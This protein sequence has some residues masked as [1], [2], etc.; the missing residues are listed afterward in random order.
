MVLPGRDVPWKAF[1]KALGSEYSGDRVSDTAGS[2]TFFAVLAIF[3]FLL[4]LVALASVVISPADA[5]SLVQQ[6]GRV[7]PPA[8]TDILSDRIRALGEDRSLGLLTFSALAAIWAA[9]GGIDALTRALNV[10]YDVEESRPWWKARAV[11]LGMTLVTA[12][13]ALAAALLAI[14]LPPIAQWL[15]G[16]LGTALL[17]LRLPVAGALMMLLWALLY[18]G[19]PNVEQKFRFLTPG[20]IFGVAVW[21]AASWGF[22]VYVRNFGN[23]EATYGAL[24]GVI[25][26]LLWMWISSQVVLLGAEANALL[27]HWSPEGK[28]AGAKRLADSGADGS[29]GG[30]SP[31][32]AR[33]P[34][35]DRRAVRRPRVTERTPATRAV[36]R[37]DESPRRGWWRIAGALGLGALFQALRRRALRS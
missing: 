20:T 29:K 27:E 7:A 1:L 15:G 10:V 22:S 32:K 13:V 30:E 2:L 11:A 28:K 3:P 4:F 18:W 9:S 25:V 31:D 26:L 33:R 36:P 6:L 37:E 17:W 5:D 8:V 23:Y 24:G 14:A 34:H 16:P 12:A 19:L 21:V 35:R